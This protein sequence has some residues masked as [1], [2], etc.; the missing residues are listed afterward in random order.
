[1]QQQ[2]ET[3][4]QIHEEEKQTKSKQTNHEQEN[5][6]PSV[7]KQQQGLEIKASS[8]KTLCKFY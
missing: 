8:S 1:M 7:A 5:H 4:K 3:L 2:G 6:E